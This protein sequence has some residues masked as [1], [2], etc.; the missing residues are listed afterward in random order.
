MTATY[1]I[2][3]ATLV[4]REHTVPLVHDA[5]DGRTLTVFSREVIGEGGEQRPYLL[6]L[7]GGPGHEATRPTSPLSGWMKRAVQDYR[8]LLLDQRGVGRSTPVGVSIPGDTPHAQAEY[9]THFRADSIVRDSEMIRQE[10]GIERWGVLGQSFGGFCS[11]T[12]L[13]FAPEGLSEAFIAGGLSPIGRAIDDVYAAT[14]KRVIQKNREYFERYPDDRARAREIFDHLDAEDVTLPNGDRLTSRRFRQL[15]AWLGDSAGF[16]NLHSVLE[17]PFGSNAFLADVTVG[18]LRFARNPIYATLHESSYADGFATRW[19]ASRLLPDEIVDEAYFTGEHVFPWM[20]ED[21][22]WLRPHREAA[23]ILAEHEWPRQFDASQ[24]GV[25]DVP[26]AAT[27]YV[28]DMY[29][30]SEFAMETASAI[31]GL[32]PWITNEYEHNGIRADGERV[33]G[34]L[35]DMVRGR[36]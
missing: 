1:R 7:Q 13:S 26:V 18:A 11:M 3:G 31:R 22:G 2:K 21:Y 30:E 14:Y 25:N 8:V 33:L 28:N 5:L 27:I 12:Y 19:S 35:I 9:L 6:Y 10:L 32:K 16:E 20:F 4:E 36:A 15:G 34:R 24:L 23:E 17:L 29:V